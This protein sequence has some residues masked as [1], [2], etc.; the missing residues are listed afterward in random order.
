MTEL[1]S[2]LTGLTLL[3][4]LSAGGQDARLGKEKDSPEEMAAFHFKV[5][6]L[7]Y[8]Q[9][10]VGLAAQSLKMGQDD[11]SSSTLNANKDGRQE[12]YWQITDKNH[13]LSTPC[14]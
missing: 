10:T 4:L 12:D 3:A 8:F 9:G 1:G 2:D 13:T 11:G 5:W 7:G 14:P 6:T